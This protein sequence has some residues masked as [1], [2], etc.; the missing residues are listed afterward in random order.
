MLNHGEKTAPWHAV[1]AAENQKM[2]RGLENTTLV[3]P[4]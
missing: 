1:D 2:P 3:E 4:A